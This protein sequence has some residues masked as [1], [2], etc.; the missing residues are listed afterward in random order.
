MQSNNSNLQVGQNIFIIIDDAGVT[1]T[2]FLGFTALLIDGITFNNIDVKVTEFCVQNRIT[3]LHARKLE[4]EGIE[5]GQLDMNEYERIYKSLFDIVIP[6]LEK[7]THVRLVNLL[8]NQIINKNIYATHYKLFKDIS[9]NLVDSKLHDKYHEFYS[10]FAFPTYEI[11]RRNIII[12]NNIPINV[13]MDR[14]DDYETIGNDRI[15]LKGNLFTIS[16]NLKE[17]AV[18]VFNAYIKKAKNNDCKITSLCITNSKN[19]AL[20]N[21]V[22]AFCNLS[23]NYAKVII[24]GD[25]NSSPAEIRKYNIYRNML[26]QNIKMTLSDIQNTDKMIKDNFQYVAKKIKSIGN[27]EISTFELFH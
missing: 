8:T 14:K 17:T 15:E 25:S 11:I 13:I 19:N 23:Y 6:E 26:I 4:I 18:Q 20:L 12:A 9:G 5:E 27:K 2:D 21:V 10:Y 7:A 16:Q 3:N 22:D 24:Q 1:N